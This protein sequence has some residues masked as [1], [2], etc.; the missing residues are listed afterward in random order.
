MSII[1]RFL[2]G[3]PTAIVSRRDGLIPDYDRFNEIYSQLAEK[4]DAYEDILS[5]QKYF[6][7]DV[8]H[9]F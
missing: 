3:F 1:R 2:E 9:Q 5:K 4:L 6:A 8:R 7:G